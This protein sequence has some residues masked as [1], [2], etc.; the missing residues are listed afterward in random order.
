MLIKPKKLQP[1]TYKLNR[2]FTII[3]LL[4]V[5]FII[6]LLASAISANL[7]LGQ[8][9]ARDRRRVADLQ[10]IAAAVEFYRS[11]NRYYPADANTVNGIYSN[12]ANWIIPGLVPT[13]IQIL[14]TDP[15]NSVTYRYQYRTDTNSQASK[16]ELNAK[17]EEDTR[18]MK[19]DVAP[20]NGG[21]D[22]YY[23]VG[24]GDQ[25]WKVIQ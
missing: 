11:K 17:L 7:I 4:V 9:K 16:Y 25:W 1:T 5:V 18:S 6:G 23:E 14:P 22:S 21:S 13:Y 19:N 2:G 12:G 24:G 3:E 20:V 8:K 10:N 15:T